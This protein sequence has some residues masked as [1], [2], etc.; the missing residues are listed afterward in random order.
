[1]AYIDFSL[2]IARDLPFYF[3]RPLEGGAQVVPSR[4]W[5]VVDLFSGV[6]GMSWGFASLSEFFEIRAAVDAERA[7]PGR[8]KSEGTSP[9]CNRSYEANL[10]IRPWT[11]DLS[12]ADPDELRQRVGMD[13]GS[14][15]V[16][17]SCAPCT[18]FSQKIAANHIVDDARNSL[19]RRTASFAESFMPRVLVMENVKELVRGRHRHHFDALIT[20]LNRLGYDV[21]AGV[22]DLS[23]FGLPQRRLRAL[24][25]ATRDDSV[26]P[27]LVE[28]PTRRTTVRDAI[29]HLP[30]VEQGEPSPEDPAHVCP[31]HSDIVTNRMRAIPRDG[32]SWADIVAT[33]PHLLVP[34]MIGKRAGSFPDVYGRLWWD[35][36][37]I[38]VTRE[39]AHPGNGRYTHPEQDRM[40][41]VREMALIQGFPP[42]YVFL[43]PLN[44]RYNQIGDAVPP[45]VSRVI[46]AHV[47]AMLAERGS[48]SG[49]AAADSA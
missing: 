15:D 20:A 1:M 36:P 33:H 18:G 35:R 27:L 47:A 26:A 8:G 11:D 38:T 13:R 49:L 44:A 24:V 28:P 10:G 45:L 2:M 29:G 31:R 17:I 22:H 48:A 42:N 9:F 43:G 7:K 39:C 40:L 46:A 3:T 6:G 4:R 37:A 30:P 34:S 21:W 41:T 14:L 12:S 25:I 19:V 5:S 32:G 16:L 23:D